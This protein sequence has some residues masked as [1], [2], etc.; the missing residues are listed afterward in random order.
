MATYLKHFCQLGK[1]HSA[2]ILSSSLRIYTPL[3][4]FIISFESCKENCY[5]LNTTPGCPYS[6]PVWL[7]DGNRIGFNHQ[8]VKSVE[9]S[10]PCFPF[11]SVTFYGD[12]DGFW[13]MNKD[14]SNMCRATTFELQT[15]AW[16]PDGK[17]IAFVE[18][19]QI[20]KMGF[21][22]AN[23][24]TTNI[25]ALSNNSGSNF[26][27]AWSLQSDTIY[28]TSNQVHPGLTFQI[29]KMAADGTGQT[30]I[31][32]KGLDSLVSGWPFY[33][34]DKKIFI[35]ELINYR[36]IYFPWTSTEIL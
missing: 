6:Q 33:T 17:W 28:Y 35:H 20:Y 29:Y 14:G 31:G 21:D 8:V 26:S 22:G 18:G 30:L 15:P 36:N 10:N 9:I 24:D 2:Q 19:E 13:L 16:S 1:K 34:P 11:Y 12:S 32:N 7:P 4:L 27:P 5:T 23:F 3:F 25:I